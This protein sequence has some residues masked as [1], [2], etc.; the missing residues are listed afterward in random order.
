MQ[1]DKISFSE[2]F[3]SKLIEFTEGLIPAEIFDKVLNLMEYEAAKY[4]FSSSSEANLLR[5]FNSVYDKI[6]FIQDLEK[7]P[8]HTEIII[9]TAGSS[10]YLTDIVV[11]NPE[12]LYQVFDQE[13]LSQNL[14]FESLKRELQNGINRY[15]SL[16]AKLNYIR[17]FKKRY[18]L[19]IGLTDILGISDLKNI[20]QQLSCLAKSIN[21]VL[22]ELCYSE[23]L[24][25]Y[26]LQTESKYCLCSLGKLGG[27]ELNYSSDVDL[28]LFYDQNSYIENLKKEYHEILSE[29]ALLFIKSSTEI[30]DRGYIYRVDFRLRP[31][32]K[33]SPLCK[34]YSD[35]TKYYETRGEDWERQMLIKLDFICGSYEL[36]K[37]FYDFLQPYIFPASFST[38]LTE[39]IKKMKR[40][41][42]LHNKEQDNVKL[43]QGGIRDIEF[44]VQA[45]QLLNGGRYK[46]LR[47]GNT[48]DAID[49]LFNR[50]LLKENEKE[51]LKKAYIFYRR[52]EHFLQL[53]NDIQTHLIPSEGEL[54]YK[55]CRYLNFDNVKDFQK[56]LKEMRKKVREIYD[57]VLG[58]DKTENENELKIIHFENINRAEKNFRYLRSGIGYFEQKEFDSRTIDLFNQIEPIL[59]K[60]LQHCS[61]PDVTLDNFVK[62][63]RS[64][65]FPS[66]WYGQL[67]NKLFFRDFLKICEYCTKAIEIL[68]LDKRIEEF[69]LSQE[70][71]VKNPK[72]HLSNYN[73]NQVIFLLSA[74]FV[75]GM[76][77]TEKVSKI[78]C[79][80][81]DL[82]INQL[83]NP[84]NS[85]YNFFIGGLGS[86]GSYMLNFSSDIDLIIVTDSVEKYSEIHNDFQKL[87]KELQTEL[88][89]FEIDFRLRPEGKSSPLVWGLESYKNY[90][91]TRARIWEFQSLSK[92]RF[93][94]GNKNLF[95][96]FKS[97]LL[98]RIRKLDHTIVQK[99]IVQM[100][101]SKL[102]ELLLHHD[103]S[104][105]IKKQRGGLLTIDFLLH[106]YFFK[107]IKLL[108]KPTF[109]F[110][111]NIKG[112]LTQEEFNQLLDNYLFLR[113]VEFA[114][115]CIFNTNNTILPSSEEK[116]L[117][118]SSFFKLRIDEFN[119]KISSIIKTNN[120]LFEKYVAKT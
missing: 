49:L 15:S 112:I 21:A 36:Y 119:K 92:L 56:E 93:I 35:Y 108:G 64:T 100:Y 77:S 57:N 34:A 83:S 51:I 41:I 46:E 22:F 29:A 12:Y 33:Y 79:D 117:L 47:T 96:K 76:L 26:N 32:G 45:L 106:S 74:Q 31:D 62:V 95:N 67:L 38:S 61:S 68:A 113:K 73:T 118:I 103:T 37:K 50:K 60:Y 63:I 65:K 75:L 39:Q 5:I 120:Y 72:E 40:N 104:F 91:D 85:I 11:R 43:F 102:K 54:L 105:N 70:A 71:F 25:K 90:L 87:L 114:I 8:H 66:I 116:K 18:I 86:Y 23:T 101:N 48:L 78:I 107:N 30:S 10:N 84:Y 17:Q 1:R 99:E 9:A 110:I 94:A 14:S 20:T 109:T 3:V 97:I 42:E 7:F 81:V 2:N 59:T 82:K 27:C 80:Y 13:Y 115:Q 6:S 52:I 53:M 4:F 88:K 16:T 28:I 19:K 44:T 89:P 24:S 55:L 69:F 111:K 98:T 58:V